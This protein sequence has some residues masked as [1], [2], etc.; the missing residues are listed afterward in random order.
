[1]CARCWITHAYPEE[2][3]FLEYFFVRP[4]LSIPR[5][6]HSTD[7]QE[8]LSSGLSF[9]L[10]IFILLRVRGNLVRRSNGWH[11]RF[12][13]RSERWLLAVS[14]DWLDSSMLRVAARLVWYPVCYGVLLVPVAVL[15]FVQFGG[16]P[17]PFWATILTDTM[18]NLQGACAMLSNAASLI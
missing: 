1:M 7:P 13:P 6:H 4:T 12:V 3:M 8:F 5:P 17:V 2:Q 10:Y 18:F 15:R 14:R 16:A 9:L 11:L